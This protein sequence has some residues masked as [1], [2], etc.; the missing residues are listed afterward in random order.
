MKIFT[1]RALF[2][3]NYTVNNIIVK[4]KLFLFKHTAWKN[5]IISRPHHKRDL[6]SFEGLWRLNYPFKWNIIQHHI[7]E[8]TCVVALATLTSSHTGLLVPF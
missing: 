7:P 6:V 8:V 2:P 3:G 1:L 4:T 5:L